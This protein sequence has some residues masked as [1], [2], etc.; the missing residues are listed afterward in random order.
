MNHSL[1]HFSGRFWQKHADQ[2]SHRPLVIVAF[3]DSVT[4]GATTQGVF[5]PEEVYH[6]RLKRMI[7]ERY[8]GPAAATLSVI[9]SGIGGDT[10]TKALLRLDRDVLCFRPDLV[11]LAFG[12]NDLSLDPAA[13]AAF[14]RSVVRMV[15]AIRA[16]TS[17]DIVIVTPTR[18]ASRENRASADEGY[19]RVLMQFQNGGVVARY[20]EIL[21]T[22]GRAEGLPVADVYAQWEQL[23]A[24]GVDTTSKL[25]NGLNHPSAEMHEIHAREIFR[26][27]Q[28]GLDLDRQNRP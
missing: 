26:I 22:V 15:S 8:P 24:S 6:S 16:Q 4:M 23:E 14:E 27:I 12:A 9:N 18:M 5:I 19:L 28:A 17:S 25:I 1:P 2:T 7:A 21:R 3:G 11:L 13:S 10:A 20:A